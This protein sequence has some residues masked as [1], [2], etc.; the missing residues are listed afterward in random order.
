MLLGAANFFDS[1]GAICAVEMHN[2]VLPGSAEFAPLWYNRLGRRDSL[3]VL[4]V[5]VSQGLYQSLGI[6]VGK[7]LHRDGRHDAALR[8]QADE[9]AH[10]ALS[11]D[12]DLSV[13]FKNTEP[14]G[15]FSRTQGILAICLGS[16]G[17]RVD[18]CR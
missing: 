6:A 7:I 8:L 14:A 10:C 18:C 16:V 11:A 17:P 12:A 15:K 9:T 4:L 5:C 3:R 1:R 13:V 2:V